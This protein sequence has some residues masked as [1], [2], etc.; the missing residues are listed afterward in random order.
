[1]ASPNLHSLSTFAKSR[2]TIDPEDDPTL[3][4]M[5]MIKQLVGRAPGLRELE[6]S[7]VRHRQS[8]HFPVPEGERLPTLESLSLDLSQVLHGLSCEDSL[9]SWAQHMDWTHLRALKL[10]SISQSQCEAICTAFES[11]IPALRELSVVIVGSIGPVGQTLVESLRTF[12]SKLDNLENISLIAD[13]PNNHHLESII[14]RPKLRR[15]THRYPPSFLVFRGHFLSLGRLAQLRGIDLD[16]LSIDFDMHKCNY[17][18]RQELDLIA[19]LDSIVELELTAHLRGEQFELL[20]P[21][22]ISKR[23]QEAFIHINKNRVDRK[24][25]SLTGTF[26]FYPSIM[27]QGLERRA[28]EIRANCSLATYDGSFDNVKTRILTNQRVQD[29]I[30][31]MVSNIQGNIS[32]QRKATHTH[33]GTESTPVQIPSAKRRRSRPFI[34]S[35]VRSSEASSPLLDSVVPTNLDD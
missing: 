27:E 25:R 20:L 5:E 9:T 7:L 6:M 26:R 35:Q 3:P 11:R 30:C 19:S 28:W 33:C 31:K 16:F 23:L 15:L 22:E 29:D 14:Q 32:S 17:W 10:E 8:P 18:K 34:P 2:S 13:M 12:I 4:S 24:L 1:M 21:E